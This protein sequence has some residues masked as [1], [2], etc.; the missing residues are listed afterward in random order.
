MLLIQTY[1]Y[2]ARRFCLCNHPHNHNQTLS[3]VT[4]RIEA[5]FWTAVL[6]ILSVVRTIAFSTLPS[7]R[8]TGTTHLSTSSTVKSEVI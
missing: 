1:Q 7:D 5:V 2:I 6:A 3:V 8:T 4:R